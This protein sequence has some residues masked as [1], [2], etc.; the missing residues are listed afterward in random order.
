[1]PKEDNYLKVSDFDLVPAETFPG[2]RHQ[3]N[4]KGSIQFNKKSEWVENEAFKWYSFVKDHPKYDKTAL[5]R[6]AFILAKHLRNMNTAV[7][8]AR[9][10]IVK[11]E[12]CN[13]P[14]EESE[15]EDETRNNSIENEVTEQMDLG[16]ENTDQNENEM[17]TTESNASQ[18]MF[19][20][21]QDEL[22]EA[23]LSRSEKDTIIA[24]TLLKP[25]EELI[26]QENELPEF[27]KKSY[28]YTSLKFEHI[29]KY[30]E[31]E[32]EG[33]SSQDIL[34]IFSQ[35]P[36]YVT[37]SELYKKRLEHLPKH[38]RSERRVLKNINE[39]LSLLQQSGTSESLNHRK[40][41]TS[42]VYD[43]R[44]GYPQLCETRTIKTASKEIKTRFRGGDI[45]D[46]K[47]DQRN[48]N[49]YFPESVKVIAE[50]CWRTNCTVIEP[51]KH[52]RPKAAIKDGSETIPIIYQT[53]T[54]KEAYAAFKEIYEE[55]VENAMAKNCEEMKEKLNKTSDT[56]LK[57]KKM[58]FIEKKKNRFPS[59]SW[60]IEQKP[61]ETK[62]SSD[63]CTG[64]CKDCEGPQLNYET[65]R[66]Y[67]KSLCQCKRKMCPNWFCTCDV[68]EFGEILEG[69]ECDPCSCDDCCQCQV[70]VC[71]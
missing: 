53:L 50:K 49:D 62:P 6:K 64:L 9:K 36:I 26:N 57:E 63:H 17:D 42:A 66:K 43:P 56:K 52:S 68:D 18:D 70:R 54:D 32:F 59:L 30:V 14:V 8:E 25:I 71:I 34:N 58:T 20:N 51:G 16:G 46:L 37:S 40:I 28:K 7:S 3:N 24:Q 5:Y 35:T 13:I 21:S 60:F 33:M 19:A 45:P 2:K 65:L 15:G 23:R 61:K 22:T 48:S 55:D 31:N 1:M 38:E 12:E 10:L 29:N 69:C 39:T 41:I 67:K 47:P 11:F 27:V 4:P 44:F